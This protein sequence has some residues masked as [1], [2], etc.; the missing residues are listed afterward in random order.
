MAVT[1]TVSPAG[2]RSLAIL[3]G[4]LEIYYAISL[5]FRDRRNFVCRRA[6][7]H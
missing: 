1:V 7:V 2:V 3:Y 6:E 5:Q 4:G